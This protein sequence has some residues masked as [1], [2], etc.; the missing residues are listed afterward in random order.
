NLSTMLA[1]MIILALLLHNTLEWVDKQYQLLRKVI[2]SR[3]RLFN[4]IRALTT[5]YALITGQNS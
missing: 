3:Q 5:Y 4:D 1:T 2:P